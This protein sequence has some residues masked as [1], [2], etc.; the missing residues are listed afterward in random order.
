ML[1]N[2]ILND[3]ILKNALNYGEP[4]NGGT[5]E[6][7]YRAVAEAGILVFAD[8]MHK[9]YI[10]PTA[11]NILWTAVK[12][13]SYTLTDLVAELF[14][15]LSTVVS[16]VK[17]GVSAAWDGIKTAGQFI[18]D[19]VKV[20]VNLVLKEALKLMVKGLFLAVSSLISTITFEE[21]PDLLKLKTGTSSLVELGLASDSSGLYLEVLLLAMPKFRLSLYDPVFLADFQ[22]ETLGLTS[23]QSMS[24]VVQLANILGFGVLMRMAKTPPN[25]NYL[26]LFQATAMTV[27]SLDFI[28]NLLPL[29]SFIDTADLEGFTHYAL[30]QSIFNGFS[31]ATLFWQ[32]RSKVN[33]FDNVAPKS[34][35][36]NQNMKELDKSYKAS[37]EFLEMMGKNSE[38]AAAKFVSSMGIWGWFARFLPYLAGMSVWGKRTL[39]ILGI[40]L[41]TVS[42]RTL[43]LTQEQILF[44]VAALSGILGAYLPFRW[45]FP[46]LKKGYDNKKNP[47]EYARKV[48]QTTRILA[49][50]PTLLLYTTYKAIMAFLML[51]LANNADLFIR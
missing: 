20:T 18:A 28:A 26:T 10:Q 42:L 51:I 7:D 36:T 11:L 21:Q 39:S 12:G 30:M 40:D 5:N 37:K 19:T 3:D 35:E 24:L 22:T 23:G 34:I 6:L 33:S 9:T 29:V 1:A 38:E 4:A 16:T 15:G 46:P 31:A 43:E 17:A 50:G 2:V 49:Y 44:L 47:Q 25:P 27:G 48:E 14:A 41:N 45:A 8:W 32:I 13:S